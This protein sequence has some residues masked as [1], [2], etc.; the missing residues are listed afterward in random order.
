MEFIGSVFR[1]A[2]MRKQITQSW[3]HLLRPALRLGPT[4]VG[5]KA[6]AL[7]DG[8]VVSKTGQKARGRFEAERRSG[9]GSRE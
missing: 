8:S 1:S 7:E 5:R 6:L 3:S 9:D 4:D 2:V